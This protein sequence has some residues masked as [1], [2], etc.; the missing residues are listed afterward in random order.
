MCSLSWSRRGDALVVVMNRDERR[1]RAPARPPRRWRGADGPF[2]A[3]L[4]GA[5]G[6]T[7]IAARDSGVVL[8]LLNH[9][10]ARGARVPA[11]PISRGRLMTTL[12]A[13]R[14]VPDA[15]RLRGAGLRSFARFRLFV[16]APATAPRVFTWNGVA[17]TS[18]RLDPRLG[19][20]TSSSWNPRTVIPA[21][22]ARFRTFRRAHP[23]PTRDD[24]VAFHERAS[25]PRGT[26][27]AICMSRADACTVSRTVV[28]VT[29]AGVSMRYRAVKL[30]GP[31]RP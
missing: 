21:R 13:E 3:P 2:T 20:L 31:G 27:W 19:F 7:W 15:A 29:T 22:Q 16:A 14:G 11:A 10:A 9:Q 17:L 6:G 28:E 26:P 23:R 5:A 30:A 4:D 18:R 8:A 24:L 25:D 12:A 1:D